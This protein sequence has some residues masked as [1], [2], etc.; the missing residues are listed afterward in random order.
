MSDQRVKIGIIGGSGLGEKLGLEQGAA[1]AVQTPFG[2]PS[3]ELVTATWEGTEVVLL[4]RHGPGHT[5]NPSAVPY[6]ANIFAL[7]AAGVTHVLAS[8]A[9]GSLREHMHPGELVLVDQVIDKTYRR[10]NTFYEKAA[11]HAEMAEPFCPVMRDWL[12]NASRSLEKTTVHPSGCYVVMEG[13]AFSTRAESL[14][15]RG[16]GGD[17]IGMTAMPEAR[18]AREAELAYAMIAMPTD[19]DAW[20]EPPPGQSK[21]QLLQEIIGN[22]QRATEAN[23][24]LMKAAL[25]DVLLLK[26]EASPAHTAL[27]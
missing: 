27:D 9:T 2:A 4:Q 10:A 19:Y 12:L 21:Q 8:G 1:E 5:L 13:P 25:K 6:R 7:K 11:V 20:R 16:W 23:L 15:H 3:S 17:L 22:L 26:R 18:L 14:M 24:S